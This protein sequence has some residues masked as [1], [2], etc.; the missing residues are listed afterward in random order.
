MSQAPIALQAQSKS[1]GGSAAS[2]LSRQIEQRTAI[3]KSPF[4]RNEVVFI[5][6]KVKNLRAV[7]D[8]ATKPK[9]PVFSV[10]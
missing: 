10:S 4:A 9:R 2:R 7:D 6:L 8:C 1:S 3:R 5:Y